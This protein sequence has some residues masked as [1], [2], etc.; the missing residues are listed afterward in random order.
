VKNIENYINKNFDIFIKGTIMSSLLAHVKVVKGQEEKFEELQKELYN[1][2]HANEDCIIRYEHY[3]GREVNSYYS[4]LVYPSYLDFL[5]KHQISKHHEEAGAQFGGVIES[6]DLEWLDPI[7][8]A[9]PVGITEMEELPENAPQ[10]AKDYIKTYPAII[11]KW[12]LKLR[13][14]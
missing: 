5:L 4:L 12:W 3:R 2:S 9:A 11:Q 1:Q 14:N 13:K 8:D 7:E 6:L 10:L